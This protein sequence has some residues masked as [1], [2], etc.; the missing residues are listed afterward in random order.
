MCEQREKEC[1]SE[2]K[3]LH[4]IMEN[5][6]MIIEESDIEKIGSNFNQFMGYIIGFIKEKPSLTPTLYRYNQ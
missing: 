1:E 2:I 4:R 6:E 3:Q 5:P